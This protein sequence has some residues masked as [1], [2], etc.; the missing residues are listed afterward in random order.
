MR[1][2]TVCKQRDQKKDHQKYYSSK[3]N[4]KPFYRRKK[5]DFY[6]IFLRYEQ[7]HRTK[8]QAICRLPAKYKRPLH[9][10]S[11]HSHGVSSLEK[12]ILWSGRVFISAR[13]SLLQRHG[14]LLQRIRNR[15]Q[16]L[17]IWTCKKMPHC[18]SRPCWTIS[19]PLH[20]IPAMIWSIEKNLQ[21]QIHFLYKQTS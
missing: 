18:W 2:P 17:W 5:M 10:F 14:S 19:I 9:I 8:S 4:G 13:V 7:R 11:R 20:T 21:R 12:R 6:W 3:E 15:G 16:E 1:R